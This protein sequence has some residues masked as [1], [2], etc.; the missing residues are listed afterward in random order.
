MIGEACLE[1]D[2]ID[3]ALKADVGTEAAGMV[4]SEFVWTCD[5]F[6]RLE[7]GIGIGIGIGC[8]EAIV[9]VMKGSTGSLYI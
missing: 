9:F 8:C 5:G 6:A 1:L 2:A 3:E 4:G 7:G